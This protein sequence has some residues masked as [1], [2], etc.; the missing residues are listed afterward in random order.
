MG[1]YTDAT[2]ANMCIWMGGNKAGVPSATSATTRYDTCVAAKA[3]VTTL[4]LWRDEK[5]AFIVNK[6]QET[7]DMK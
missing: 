5:N 4:L 2:T 3:K 7:N 6:I 1:D